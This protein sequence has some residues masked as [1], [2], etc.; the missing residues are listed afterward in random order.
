MEKTLKEVKNLLKK[1]YDEEGTLAKKF[2]AVGLTSKKNLCI[3]KDVN[4]WRKGERVE[5]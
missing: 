1:R 3:H 5:V 2:L 4:E